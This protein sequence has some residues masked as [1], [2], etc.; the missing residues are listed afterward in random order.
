MSDSIVHALALRCHSTRIDVCVAV[1]R[2]FRSK[3][4]EG[5][6]SIETQQARPAVSK[7]P[8]A[9]ILEFDSFGWKQSRAGLV[10]NTGSLCEGFC[11]PRNILMDPWV[12]VIRHI[13]RLGCVGC[14]TLIVAAERR[15]TPSGAARIDAAR[16]A[17][18]LLLPP[19]DRGSQ[20]AGDTSERVDSLS[21]N[22]TYSSAGIFIT[23]ELAKLHQ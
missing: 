15:G 4:R 23:H 5:G 22:K 7:D 18:L 11:P 2:G 9:D 1:W 10:F 6:E 19:V 3:E 14:S 21:R 16:E 20:C 8:D 17:V 12:G 13:Q